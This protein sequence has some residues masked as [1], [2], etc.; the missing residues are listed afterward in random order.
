MSEETKPGEFI[1]M[2]LRAKLE[3]AHATI[4]ELVRALEDISKTECCTLSRCKPI[5][6]ANAALEKVKK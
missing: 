1:A 4:E 2:E 6:K 3:T 5:Q